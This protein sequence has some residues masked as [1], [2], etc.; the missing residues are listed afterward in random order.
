M[1]AHA[2]MMHVAP[3]KS[4]WC[5]MRFLHVLLCVR[6]TASGDGSVC[7]TFPGRFLLCCA[8][9]PA[10]SAVRCEPTAAG[11][12]CADLCGPLQFSARSRLRRGVVVLARMLTC[13]GVSVLA[14]LLVGCMVTVYTC[15]VAPCLQ[16]N[17]KSPRPF[18]VSCT[19]VA[20]LLYILRASRTHVAANA[21]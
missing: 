14:L 20:P 13:E 8:S 16:G 6:S 5:C 15:S 12:P 3:V 19:N 4:L 9:R 7:G 1:R 17:P 18:D 10:A 11:T 21:V 2:T